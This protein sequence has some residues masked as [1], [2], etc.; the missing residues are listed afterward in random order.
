M[1]AGIDGDTRPPT[2]TGSLVKV[3]DL[4]Q[5][6]RG[7]TVLR[8][9]D[10]DVGPGVLGILGPNGAGKTT[11]LRTLATATPAKAGRV[12][13]L[14][15]DTTDAGQLRDVRRRLGFLPQA[16]GYFPGF[17]I[18]EFIE[19][20]AW[21]REVP[22]P[23]IAGRVREALA[24]VNLLGQRDLKM[25]RLSGG[26]LRRAGIAQAIV[27]E[28]ELL[29]LDEPTAGLDPEQRMDFRALIRRYGE[30]GSVIVATHLV[31]DVATACSDVMVMWDG[32][33]AFRGDPAELA[34]TGGDPG[35]V[36]DNATERGYTAVLRRARGAT[37]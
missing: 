35:G 4:T 34:A 9:V 24:A 31:E 18:E 13:L 16:F 21:L 28:P 15:R 3:R 27:N 25:K 8:G 37:A 12:E 11:L 14:G 6:Y 7:R 36:G 23:L 19:Y 2:T 10:L 17:S 5:G 32:R 22:R 20:S 1:I 26:M 33:F 30:R 29:I